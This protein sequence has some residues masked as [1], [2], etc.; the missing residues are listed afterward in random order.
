[1]R[2]VGRYA[3]CSL[4]ATC[5]C[6]PDVTG[7]E[8]ELD[9]EASRVVVW[10]PRAGVFGFLGHDHMIRVTRFDGR[11]H[12]DEGSPANAQLT[13]E[14]CAS[15]LKVI[16]EGLNKK[17]RTEVQQT[18]ESERVLDAESHPEIRFDSTSIAPG[19]SGEWIITGELTIRGVSREVSFPAQLSF[20]SSR[21][22][23]AS[24]V[25]QLKPSSFGIAPV[26][27]VGGTIRT[28]DS[29]ELRF[30]VFGRKAEQ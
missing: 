20:P 21:N 30:H 14:A 25:V 4:L 10:V 22:L 7:A 28:A 17:E 15:C 11:L 1:M 13:F 5:M 8:Y 16:D 9:W 2:K 6:S 23:E 24:G 29:I 26:T 18:M 27:A 19:N 3:L 12:W